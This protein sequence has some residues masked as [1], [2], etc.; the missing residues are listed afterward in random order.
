MFR[1]RCY[2]MSGMND[3]MMGNKQAMDMPGMGDQK[4][5][6]KDDNMNCCMPGIMC[7]PIYECPQ[8]R[9]CH[10]QINHE[11]NH[12][13]PV[14]TRIINHHVYHHTYTPCYTCC[15]E[16]EVSNVVDNKCCL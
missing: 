3:P 14:N 10:R 2:D 13:I 15:E 6:V 8:E 16:N 9:C 5:M 4:D 11:V 1:N 12:I 7:P